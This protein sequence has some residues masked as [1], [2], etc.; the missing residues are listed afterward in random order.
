M[1]VLVLLAAIVPASAGAHGSD[2]SSKVRRMQ[3]R[4]DR[5][6][7]RVGAVEH[8]LG[9]LSAAYSVLSEQ[10]LAVRTINQNQTRNIADLWRAIDELRGEHPDDHPHDPDHPPCGPCPLDD[11][12]GGLPSMACGC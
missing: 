5:L 10:L 1:A 11:D 2:E 8:E 6:Y 7:L 4:M 3:Q 12:H 9:E